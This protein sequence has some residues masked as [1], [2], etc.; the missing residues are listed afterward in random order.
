MKSI[1]AMIRQIEGL[2][3]TPD[4]TAWENEFIESIVTRTHHGKATTTLT[5]GQITSIQRIYKKHFG[6]A[7]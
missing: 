5:D 2:A 7:D 6:D 3:D 1:G 4:V